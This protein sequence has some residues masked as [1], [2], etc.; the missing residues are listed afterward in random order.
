MQPNIFLTVDDS[1][2]MQWSHVPDEIRGYDGT[3]KAKS[4][5]FNPLYYNPEV[6]YSPPVDHTGA[7]L[8]DATFTAAWSDGYH[9]NS[10]CT[11]DLS[12][13]FRPTWGAVNAD[14]CDNIDTLD[15]GRGNEFAGPAEPA[16]YY[17]FDNIVGDGDIDNDANYTK[18][19]VGAAEQ[20]NFANWYSYYRKRIFTAKAAITHSFAAFGPIFRMSYQTI[21]DQSLTTLAEYNGTARQNFYD[22]IIGLDSLGGTPLRTALLNVGQTVAASDDPYRDD[23]SDPSSSVRSCRQ[24]FHIL[25]TDGRWNGNDPS[26]GNVDESDHTLPTNDFD[27]TTYSSTEDYAEPY[28]DD[29]SDYLADVAF[30]Y[31]ATDLRPDMEN[32]VPYSI[33]KWIYDSTGGANQPSLDKSAT[34]WHP[35]NNP[36][37]WQH[38]VNL[39]IGLGVDGDLSYPDDLENLID[40]SA[41]WGSG[42]IDDLWHAAINSRGRYL[43]ARDPEALTSNFYEALTKALYDSTTAAPVALNSGSI[44]SD[45]RLFQLKFHAADWSGELLSL[46]ISDG[47]SNGTCTAGHD[48]GDV[49]A[50]EW[51]AGCIL[52]GGYCEET[53]TTET[54]LDW[55]TGRNIITLNPNTGEGVPFRWNNLYADATVTT[56]QQGL[57]DGTDSRG[58]DR[59]EYLRGNRSYEEQQDNNGTCPDCIFRNRNSVLGDL[60]NSSPIYVGAPTRVYPDNLE[61]ANHSTFR[62]NQNSRQSIV[63]VGGNDGM[64]HGFSSTTGVEEIAYVPNIIFSKLALLTD[65]TYNHASFVDGQLEEGDAFFDGAWHTVLLGGFGYGGQG[66]YALDITS[67]SDFSEANASSIVMWEYS[68]ADDADLGYTYGTPLIR[69]LNN[70]TWAAIFGNGYDSTVPDDNTSETGNAAIYIVDISNGE[71]IQKISTEVG[72]A[73]DPTGSGRPNGIAGIEPID[74]NDDYMVDFIYAGDLFGNIWRFNLE[75]DIPENWGVSF[76]GN[77]LY[78][79]KDDNNNA[80][81][82]TT[83][84]AVGHHQ[85]YVG[86][87][88]YFGT[89]K[90]LGIN[91]TTDISQQ[92]FYGIWDRWFDND[93]DTTTNED[94]FTAFSRIDLLEQEI[95]GTNEAQFSDSEARVT[96]N[97]PIDWGTHQ[98]WYL[99]LTETGE[100][101][102]QSPLLRNERIIFV[103]VTPSDDPCESGGTSWLMELDAYTGSRLGTS[104]FDYSLDGAFTSED[105][106]EYDTDG[107]GNAE[108]IAGSGIRLGD[109]IYTIPA[110]INMPGSDSE[111][112]YI[113]TSAGNVE[114]IDESSGRRVKQ[115]WRQVMECGI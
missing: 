2:S 72:T 63:Y 76:N 88:I 86:T 40:G 55:D 3:N 93:A 47:S 109:D 30:Y 110:V 31:W 103:T 20:Q 29:N 36:A 61:S 95:L 16:Y 112:K 37:N 19:V 75:G 92:T 62:D 14:N 73:Q 99:D 60:I 12:T 67:P 15:D 80:Q 69:K 106:V 25:M 87:M 58:S 34:F 108:N 84:P 83:L 70:G 79:A 100:R 10:T 39:T 21:N 41:N 46:P 89:G 5:T 4:N 115:S 6:T 114:V 94:D 42:E 43:N 68:D 104:P 82:I 71:L 11:V 28:A 51:E 7:S 96:T 49:C 54:A 24:N 64:L 102:F 81:P 90:Y 56:D 33:D 45:T 23:P 18:V 38:L 77:P 59:L 74:V 1:R 53:G 105:Q 32:N 57:L 91:D 27:I 17:R 111:R 35:E 48:I 13:S 8:G 9:K 113:G 66:V 107:D 52:T 78:T 44:S 85:T 50:A 22:W 26:V 65:P 98:G 97:N 101:A